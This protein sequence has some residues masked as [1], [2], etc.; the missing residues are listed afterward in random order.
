[1]DPQ[2]LVSQAERKASSSGGFFSKMMGSSTYQLE[3]AADLYIQAA[4]AFRLKKDGASA[5]QAF[6]KA[7][8]LQKQSEGRDEAANTLIEAYKAYRTEKPRDAARVLKEAV[9]LFTLRGQFRRAAQYEMDLG[10]M[11]EN[12]L[13][14]IDEAVKSYE[15]AGDWFFNDRAEAL[16]NK[17]FIRLAELAALQGNYDVSVENFERVAR[18]SLNSNLSKWSLKDY[19]FRAIFATLAQGDAV[20]ANLNL[21]KYVQWDP[22]FASTKEFQYCQAFIDALRDND[23]QTF[24]NKLWEYDQF[25]KLD[26]WKITM[27]LKIKQALDAPDDELL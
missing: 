9:H 8:D 14:D 5:G 3:D 7:A 26:Q 12:E 2:S 16:S 20:A 11:F 10:A 18:Q 27:G 24:T 15:N 25:S 1:M 22:S 6:E 4:N 13:E 23:E 19:F 21:E 17:A